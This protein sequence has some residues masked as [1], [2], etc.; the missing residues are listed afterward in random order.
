M[1]KLDEIMNGEH[2]IKKLRIE[3][4]TIG[5]DTEQDN[6]WNLTPR[7]IENIIYNLQRT[8]QKLKTELEL[9]IDNNNY[10]ENIFE[11]IEKYILELKQNAPEEQALDKI[12][13]IMQGDADG[14]N[15]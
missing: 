11:N 13:N 8:N 14:F 12:L 2:E 7:D 9:R 3:G 15:K 1:T 4:D 10:L 5:F 6:N